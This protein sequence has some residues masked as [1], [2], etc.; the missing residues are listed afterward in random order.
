MHYDT[1][2]PD[3][4]PAQAVG[5]CT[6]WNNYSCIADYCN[7]NRV[8]DPLDTYIKPAAKFFVD[9]LSSDFD[10]IGIVT[11]DREGVHVLSLNS[12]FNAVKTAIDGLDAY[13]EYGRSTN[14]G[15]GIFFAHTGMADEG[16]L[17]AIW[18][19]L[20]LTDGRANVYRSCSGCPPDCS[21][22]ACQTLYDDDHAGPNATKWATDNA[23]DTWNRHETVI[24]TIAYGDIFLVDPDYKDLMIL[25]ADITDNGTV[26]GVTDNFWLAPDETSLYDA[27]EE[28]A[29]RFFTRLLR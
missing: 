17:D 26:D 16:R 3:G 15:D 5:G 18:A 13:R 28:I 11:Y 9:K 22:S 27:L 14:I 23:Y 12:D 6:D 29:E 24:Y 7:A 8:C 21:A 2:K 20:F 25:V 1:P 10:R 19:V 4:W